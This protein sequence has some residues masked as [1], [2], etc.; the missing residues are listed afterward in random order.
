MSQNEPSPVSAREQAL[1]LIKFRPR[2][3]GELR[4]RLSRRHFSGSEI[5]TV[6]LEL[7]QK[8]LVDDARFAQLFAAQ[9]M[10]SRPV[11]RRGLL[12]QLRAKGI[13]G[14]M[15]QQAVDVETTGDSERA[16]AYKLTEQRIARM[17]G[18]SPQAVERRLYG[19]LTRR[20]FPAD[21]IHEAIKKARVSKN[22]PSPRSCDQGDS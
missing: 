15:A 17:K 22:E 13:H 1:R 2:S 14:E 4:V 7:R 19:F 3:E 12:A 9:R 6:L 21:V 5:E 18:L 11:G 16:L 8:G 20:G 10:S